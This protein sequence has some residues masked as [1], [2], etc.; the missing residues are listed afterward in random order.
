[1]QEMRVTAFK[2]FAEDVR[3]GDFPGPE[4]IV[5]IGEDVTEQFTEAV[6]R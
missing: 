6:D 1:M 2:Q 5:E 4:H 3:G